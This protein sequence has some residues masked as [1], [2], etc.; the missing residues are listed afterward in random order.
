MGLRFPLAPS[1]I[2]NHSAGRIEL[3][4]ARRKTERGVLLP[5]TGEPLLKRVQVLE[6][7]VAG[8]ELTALSG[9]PDILEMAVLCPASRR[10]DRDRWLLPRDPLH[11][12]GVTR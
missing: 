2:R 1:P 7:I 12:G 11:G 10:E 6:V 4:G 8:V 9:H 3:H 5:R